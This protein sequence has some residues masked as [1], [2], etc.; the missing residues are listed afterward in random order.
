MRHITILI[1]FLQIL[2]CVCNAQDKKT[3]SLREVIRVTSEDTGK[4]RSINRLSYWLWKGNELPEAKSYALQGELLGQKLNDKKGITAAMILL[5]N[6]SKSEEDYP[7]ALKNYFEALKILESLSP[8]TPGE[9][10]ALIDKAKCLNNI[11]MVYKGQGEYFKALDYYCRSLRI[12][13][14]AGDKTEIAGSMGSIA[15]VYAQMANYPKALEFN[16]KALKYLEQ[17]VNL[18]S[19]EK[20]KADKTQMIFLLG[21][22]ANI[23]MLIEDYTKSFENY[24]RAYK[25]AEEID[26]KLGMA[27]QL[28][29]I[30][31]LYY[32][33]DEYAS[34]LEFYSKAIKLAEQ[35][36]NRK[37][38]ALQMGNMG[39]AYADMADKK[40]SPESDTL[41][42]RA[43][44]LFL[45]TLEIDEGMGIKS[46]AAIQLINIG[47]VYL[48][49]R[50]MKEAEEYLL[51]GLH[52]AEEIGFL[53][54]IKSAHEDLSRYYEKKGNP[55]KALEHYKSY[56]RVRDSIFSEENTK[57]NVQLDMQYEF[58]KKEAEA[59]AE[60]DKK[61]AV[62]KAESKKQRIII[63]S[64]S[65][66]LLLVLILVLIVLRSLR[67]NQKKNRIITEQKEIVEKQKHLVEEKQKE[68]L[69]S[70]YYARRI[71]RALITSEWYID[72][73]LNELKKS[74]DQL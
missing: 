51:R 67:L 33:K 29:N 70:I 27:R 57:K 7:G 68:I 72:R 34:A 35:V 63:I 4:V 14:A 5:G 43:L 3:D 53:D 10:W 16:L 64:V 56:I 73:N 54:E 47:S 42:N 62:A 18:N 1:C 38:V 24:E 9:E 71:Q 26:D 30:G 36:K 6:I 25:L 45:K 8:A 19:A 22:M 69:D 59:R 23:Y 55:A 32:G 46:S 39:S 44:V 2:T 12:K 13:E 49:Q 21:N 74:G 28:G 41:R 66:G 48:A 40:T 17:N 15:G 61:D 52:L 11:G 60:Q 20:S 31:S 50:K 37:M 58:D 65:S